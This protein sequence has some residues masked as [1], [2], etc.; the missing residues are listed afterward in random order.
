MYLKFPPV[1][2]LI[3]LRENPKGCFQIGACLMCFRPGQKHAANFFHANY[4]A[5]FSAKPNTLGLIRTHWLPA[6]TRKILCLQGSK[7]PLR[8]L[9]GVSAETDGRQT[10]NGSTRTRIH[11]GLY[12]LLEIR[13]KDSRPKNPQA[14]A[15]DSSHSANKNHLEN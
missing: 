6:L 12:Q 4:Q 2:I 8:G 15:F 11:R 13:T 9:T 10:S 3:R 5:I 1:F 14:R 7:S